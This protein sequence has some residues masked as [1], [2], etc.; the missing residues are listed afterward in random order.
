MRLRGIFFI[1]K[2]PEPICRRAGLLI[3]FAPSHC[4]DRKVGYLVSEKSL[5]SSTAFQGHLCLSDIKSPGT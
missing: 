3:G 4:I 5:E 2:A 1:G